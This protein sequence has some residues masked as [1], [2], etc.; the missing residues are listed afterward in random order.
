[1]IRLLVI[2]ILMTFHCSIWAVPARLP[3][4]ASCHGMDGKSLQPIWPNLAGQSQKYMA[5]QLS[6]Y[7]NKKRPSDIMQNIAALL[8]DQDIEELSA[9]YSQQPCLTSPTK[10][11]PL[12]KAGEQL[13]KLG[14]YKRKIPACSACHGPLGRGND[15]AKYPG[16]AKQNQEYFI[17]QLYAFKNHQ[18]NT[19]PMGVMQD[20]SARLSTDDM[21]ALADYIQS[22]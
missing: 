4:C 9:Y 15:P 13:Y 2:F 3:L 12:H 8:N 11:L 10:P 21:Q 20:I 19:D 14:D 6:L 22:L 17:Q 18:R 16:L 1:M 5:E 7:K